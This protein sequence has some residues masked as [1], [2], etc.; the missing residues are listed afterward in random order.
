MAQFTF[1]QSFLDQLN[2]GQQ[3]AQ[4]NAELQMR[5]KQVESDLLTDEVQRQTARAQQALAEAR[6]KEVEKRVADANIDNTKAQTDLLKGRTD[7]IAEETKTEKTNRKLLKSKIGLTDERINYIKAT[8]GLK[9]E[10]ILS[11]V[12]SRDLTK[13]QIQNMKAEE[14]FTLKN[15]DKVDAEIDRLAAETGLTRE[16]ISTELLKHGMMGEEIT[17]TKLTNAALQNQLALAKRRFTVKNGLGEPFGIK[18]GRELTF[19]ELRSLVRDNADLEGKETQNKLMQLQAEAFKELS[20]AAKRVTEA[21]YEQEDN[22]S[23]KQEHERQTGFAPF[24][25]TFGPDLY[26]PDFMNDLQTADPEAYNQ[27]NQPFTDPSNIFVQPSSFL[28]SSAQGLEAANRELGVLN[29]MYP[30]TAQPFVPTFGT[31]GM[32]LQQQGS[33]L[34]PVMQQQA[35][36]SG[37]QFMPMMPQTPQQ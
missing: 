24:E 27:A 35:I 16:Q 34:A 28:P 1:G 12:Q 14:L 25:T 18:D 3:R 17:N 15:V 7:L 6:F 5:A 37:Y 19:G 10:E 2:R 13:Q 23:L 8:T 20:G 26:H 21:M 29:A 30:S 11:E 31:G 4:S 9:N 36:G 22:A 33:L 32:Q